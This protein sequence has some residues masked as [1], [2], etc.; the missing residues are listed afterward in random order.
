M[1]EDDQASVVNNIETISPLLFNT[2]K[3][4][5]K[6]KIIFNLFFKYFRMKM[7]II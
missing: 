6:H 2:V 5:E 1:Q 4:I 7:K 3:L